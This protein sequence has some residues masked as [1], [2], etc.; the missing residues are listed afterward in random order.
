MI[1]P[2]PSHIPII[3]KG[4]YP[5]RQGN[6]VRPLVDGE[7]AFRRICEATEA[8]RHSVW[9]TVTFLRP[10]FLMPD[11]RGTFFDV[12]DRC[13]ARGLDVRVL[14]WQLGPE[15]SRYADGVFSGPRARRELEA[16]GS[17]FQARWDRAH[18]GYCQHQKS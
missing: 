11:G 12:L 5:L 15:T 6:V 8:A 9:V 7:P 1:E 3:A 14:F 10:G 4:S 18:G 17:T 2:T 13:V 16:R